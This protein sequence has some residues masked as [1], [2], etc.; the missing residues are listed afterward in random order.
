V[1][2]GAARLGLGLAVAGAV[3]VAVPR[4]AHADEAGPAGGARANAAQRE[5]EAEKWSKGDTEF[6]LV[7]VVG[8]DS[9]VGFG[10][11]YTASFAATRPGVKPYVWRLES[12]GALT[13]RFGGEKVRVGYLEESLLFVTPHAWFEAL[14]LE[15]T[16]SYTIE[17]TLRYY[18]LGNASAVSAG[19]SD[20]DPYF[21]YELRHSNAAVTLTYRLKRHVLFSWGLGETH[22]TLGYAADSRLAADLAAGEPAAQRLLHV[23]PRFDVVRFTYGVGWDSRDNEVSTH[24]GQYHTLRADL[25]PGGI[26]AVPYTW[27]R[28]DLALRGYVTLVPR[29]LIFAARGVLDWLAG[30]PPF[31]ELARFDDTPALGGGKGVRGVPAGRYYGMV[32]AFAN[33][34]LRS[35]LFRFRFLSKRNVFGVT[36]FIDGGRLWSGVPRSEELD[37]TG[38]GLKLGVGGG[39]RVAAGDSFV[40][41]A[42][43]AWSKDASPVG[44]YLLA[45]QLF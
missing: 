13:L 3:A 20:S 40:L 45:G 24:H 4:L 39:L 32:K 9:D 44:A 33:L 1:R 6:T 23:A 16:A 36:G 35:E 27:A 25:A 11:G 28:F 2:A 41:R 22:N 12:S 26:D 38:L 43:V 18:G 34:E 17:P 7:P 29:R 42:D 30:D 19:H 5:A 10:G 37:G 15:A 8:G 14:R 21:E 31:Y